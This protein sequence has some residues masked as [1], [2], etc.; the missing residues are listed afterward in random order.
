MLPSFAQDTITILTPGTKRVHGADVVDWSPAAVSTRTVE[1]CWCSPASTS[2]MA[3]RGRDTTLDAWNV[4]LDSEAVP[5]TS[6]DKV[7]LPNGRDYRVQGEP[8]P[9]PSASGMLAD[10]RLYLEKWTNRG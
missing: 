3:D 6:Q 8:T 5:P 7:L 10:W 4:L 2:E 1:G 9:E